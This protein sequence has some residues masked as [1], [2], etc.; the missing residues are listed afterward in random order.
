MIP[1]GFLYRA[2]LTSYASLDSAS[3]DLQLQ[4]A[5]IAGNN[6]NWTISPA[7]TVGKMPTITDVK[8]SEVENT[9]KEYSYKL[10]RNYPNPFNPSTI[11]SY[12]LAKRG[13]V[14]LKIYDVLGREVATLVNKNQ[15]AGNYEVQF[16]ASAS[17]AT[18]RNLTSGI[19]FYRLQSGNFVESK[20]MVLVK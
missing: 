14:K 19:Y 9:I 12:S 6:T 4:F 10:N 17:S 15:S 18:A 16:D 1:I 5:D 20:K 7:F 8:D 3:I 11:I 2:D 13:N